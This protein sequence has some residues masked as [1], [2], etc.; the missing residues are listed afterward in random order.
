MRQAWT[1]GNYLFQ[2]VMSEPLRTR[3]LPMKQFMT[4][5]RQTE[6]AA[7]NDHVAE[8]YRTHGLT[9]RIGDVDVLA[10]DLAQRRLLVLEC[11]DLE[12]ARTPSELKNEI[13]YTFAQG[14]AKK[15]KLE[16]HLE[17]I[18]WISEHLAAVIEWLGGDAAAAGD[19]T[20]DGRLITDIE[21]L[22]RTSS[23][24]RRSR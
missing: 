11:K 17:R 9:E 20:V 12:G 19:W 15:S 4:Q 7:F 18:A 13:D 21:V 14:R 5:R 23:A 1:A 3:T 22:A 8:L 24:H 10:A 16:I 6:T 2:L